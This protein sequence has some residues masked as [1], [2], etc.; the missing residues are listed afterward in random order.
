M[1]FDNP[2]YAPL[3]GD[4]EISALFTPQAEID[5]MIRVERALARAQANVGVV[6]EAA[7]RVIDTGLNDVQISASDLAAG[8]AAAGVPVPALV[9]ALRER[10]PGD[11][12]HWIHWGATTQDIMDCALLLRLRDGF[13]VLQ[14]RLAAP[15]STLADMA[16]TY[17]DTSMAG[18]TRTQVATPI[19]F[20]LRAAYW[21]Q[22][23][24]D[25]RDRLA[26]VRDIC[27]KVQFGGAS[28]SNSA[29][30]PN[31]PS[32]IEALAAELDL[33]A[34]PPW[35]TNRAGVL[36]VTNWCAGTAGAAAR[37]AGDILLLARREI[38]EVRL[39]GGG[40]SSTMPNK[41]NPVSAE[42][43]VALGRYAATLATPAALSMHHHEDRDSTAWMLEW[44]VIPQAIVC[45]G[46]CLRNLQA[47]LENL[48][49]DPEAMQRTLAL[50]GGA[51]LAEAASF[52]LA[53]QMPRAEAQ[54]VV[55][56]A[57]FEARSSERG[58]TEI[59]IDQTGIPGLAE[60]IETEASHGAGYDIIASIV[61]RARNGQ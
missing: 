40:G 48:S 14:K 61:E 56:A 28:G 60:Q 5:A 58:L 26:A 54:A 34:A 45:A 19:S 1:I 31:G 3:L 44:L 53:K 4:S 41:S 24:L 52:A 51:A 11:E 50:D 23:L 55:K 20:G 59:L 8:T 30:A 15:I 47:T 46:A 21:L 7:A 13:D 36:E 25:Q 57:A 29:V 42:V 17:A 22:G 32:I 35:H 16:E 49:T 6:P 33:H 43:V 18:R 12:A 9:A 38:A 27:G 37:I 2:L 10:L 39:S